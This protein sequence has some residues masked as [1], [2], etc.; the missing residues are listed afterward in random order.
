MC[1]ITMGALLTNCTQLISLPGFGICA[2]LNVDTPD[3][4]ALFADV[5]PDSHIRKWEIRGEVSQMGVGKCG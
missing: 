4:L 2:T 5:T 3:C 1:Y